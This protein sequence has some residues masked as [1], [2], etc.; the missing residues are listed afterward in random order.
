[1]MKNKTFLLVLFAALFSVAANAQITGTVLEE[2]TDFPIIGAS[3]VEVGTTNG[4]ITDFDG[5]FVLNVAEGTQLQISYMGFQAQTLAAKDGMIVKLEEDTYVLQEVVAIGYGSQ[6]KK[7]VT[8]S[9]ASIKAEDFN[10]GVKS[11]PVGLLQGK[12]AGLNI[13]NNSA[14]PTSGGYSIQIRGFST[15]DKGAGSS[16]LYIVDGIPV[17]NIDNI[18][19][20]EIASMDVLKDGS[21]AAIY[22]TRGTNGVI[23]IT[24]KRGEG[25]SD[26]PTTQVEYSGYVSTSWVNP[27]EFINLKEISGGKIEPTLYYQHTKFD[28][29]GVPTDSVLNRTNWMKELTR[30]AAITHNHNLAITG[31]HKNFNY[32]ASV[33]F[34]YAEGI[35]KN[36]NRQ[37]VMA[38]IAAQQKALNGWLDLQYDMSYMHYRNDYFCGD[39]KM[40][41]TLNPTYPIYNID[42]TYFK[43]T[44]TGLSN[45]VENMNQKES[46]Q[47]GNYFRG[48]VKA[49]VNIKAV[50][51]LKI[52]G[53]AAI[54]EGDNRNYWAN[55]QIS[56]D[57]GGS[58]MAGRSNSMNFN[59]LY[60]ATVDYAGQW[61]SHSLV[62][63]AGFSYQKFMYDGSDMSNK[64][65][66]TES[67][68]YYQMGNGDATKQYLNVSSYRNSNAL[69]AAFIRLNY[70]YD[71]KYLLSASLRA[72]G[73]SR[74]GANNKWGY[75][76]A[77]SAGWRIK[78]EDFMSDAEWCDDLKLRLGFG[79]T[80]NNLGSDLQSVA[81][82]SNGGTFWYN[83]AY[84]YTYAVSRNVN[85]DL[86]WEKKFEYNIGVDYSFFNNRLYGSL[87]AYYRNTQDLLWDYEVPT[88]PY[89]YPTLL[90]NAG[91]M[92][93][94]GVE[95]AIS[96]VP[97]KTKDWTWVST[98]TIA[99]NRCY[100]SKLSD[101]EKGFNYTQT[102]SG[103]IGGEN[104]LMNTNTQILIEGQSIGEFYGYQFEGLK[105][106][107]TFMYKTPKGGYTSS[108]VESDRQALANAQPAVTYGWNNTVKWRNL[109]MTIFFRGVIGNKILNVTRIAYGPQA[110]MSSNVF[111]HD[112]NN[113]YIQDGKDMG[114][115]YSNKTD[116]SNYY[117][118]DG[119][120]L[121]L[122]NITV[123]YTFRFKENKY[124]QSL[125]LYATAQNLFTI[126]KYSGQDP[127][128]N[129]TNVW[130]AGIDDVSFY[131]STASCMVGVN[132]TLF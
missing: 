66:P 44:G 90:A 121:K 119:S 40:A 62:G 12:V 101:P 13:I 5:N 57:E 84:V 39:F 46:Y 51:G 104:G 16:P 106:D 28:D 38:K 100:I 109:D 48:S 99:W 24:T 112:V 117:L 124:A 27:D 88:P 79:V 75:F 130:G 59:Q 83:G 98:P 67:M 22:G 31:S 42:G 36:N 71:D 14:D 72:E 25:F 2:A 43:P 73:S 17:N 18:A 116:F 68:K 10:A 49:T 41:A 77:V 26:T 4:V 113:H 34:K 81:M 110:S 20:E 53:F 29:K 23:L 103:G 95:L 132:L 107:G 111:M 61:G 55:K 91:A 86:R 70:N 35:A 105:S 74:F 120:Y 11:N 37:E 118:E 129:T 123:G 58:G 93:S 32:R 6:K 50:E 94:Y 128:V 54:E 108:P 56:T 19:P 52:S 85:P 33:A 3:V 80:G 82:L 131:P 102:T 115:I 97:V 69:A 78:G 15:L 60:E 63:V 114:I 30:T 21:A 8:G 65:F 47:D 125:R 122:D 1:M 76:P 64:G 92:D 45:P 9:V 89:Q 126:S 7:E 127:E 96:G 87:D